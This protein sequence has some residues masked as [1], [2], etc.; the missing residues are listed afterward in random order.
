MAA[1]LGLTTVLPYAIINDNG[2]PLRW[3]YVSPIEYR[4]N[5]NGEP[6]TG[7][8]TLVQNS[9]DAWNSVV[10][11]SFEWSYAGGTGAQG[12]N[13]GD[14]TNVVN[15]VDIND[16]LGGLTLAAAASF[17]NAATTHTYDSTTF[18]NIQQVDIVYNLD[19]GVEFIANAAIS[20]GCSGKYSFEAVTMHEAGHGL[21]LAHPDT[22]DPGYSGG[23]AG[24]I[25]YSTLQDC[26]DTKGTLKADDVQGVSY[27]YDSGAPL[28]YPAFDADRLGG[29][30]PQ[31]IVFTDQSVGATSWLWTFGDGE[32]STEQSPVHTYQTPGTYSASLEVNGGVATAG[33]VEI[34]IHVAP[35]VEFQAIG[36][37]GDPP[38]SVEFVNQSSGSIFAFSWNFGDGGSSTENSP[39]HV[40]NSDGRYDVTLTA[41]GVAGPISTTKED[42]VIVGADSGGN[43]FSEFMQDMGC[44]CRVQAP[45]ARHIRPSWVLLLIAA[46]GVVAIRRRRL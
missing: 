16:D 13:A 7:S 3:Q 43:P 34:T 11:S 19:D 37:A 8:V 40:Y 18:I 39:T 28:V 4:V 41:T 5:A 38:L 33:P 44:Q 36:T 1:A 10:S 17:F 12:F 15:F 27:L 45:G 22:D 30:A 24:A 21:G 31:D 25:M 2:T 6:V 46:A 23:Y 26:D 29:Y 20:G 32:T 14:G 35:V 42:F 9:L